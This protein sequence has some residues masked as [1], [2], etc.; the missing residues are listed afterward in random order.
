MS[1]YITSAAVARRIQD[2]LPASIRLAWLCPLCSCQLRFTGYDTP[3]Q[4]QQ[5]DQQQHDGQGSATPV[6]G[7]GYDDDTDSSEDGRQVLVTIVSPCDES[8]TY[9]ML[10][11][12]SSNL[13][14]VSY[15]ATSVFLV[16]LIL[17]RDAGG[18]GCDRPREGGTVL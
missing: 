10:R 14:G 5:L 18:R 2:T 11:V 15:A 3:E 12:C 6:D 1:T 4:E 13:K 16:N 8:A 7:S 17:Q 9:C